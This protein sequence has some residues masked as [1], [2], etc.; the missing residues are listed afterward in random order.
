MVEPML[1]PGSTESESDH[2]LG[3]IVSYVR[4]GAIRNLTKIVGV[5]ALIQSQPSLSGR[6]AGL[7]G[8]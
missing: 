1:K 2:L 3:S 8:R 7:R 6:I 4:Y 5:E